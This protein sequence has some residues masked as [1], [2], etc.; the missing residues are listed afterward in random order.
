MH[1]RQLKVMCLLVNKKLAVTENYLGK[2]SSEGCLCYIIYFRN[3]LEFSKLQKCCPS[4]HNTLGK[5]S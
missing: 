3:V 1:L 4:F 2:K 5:D